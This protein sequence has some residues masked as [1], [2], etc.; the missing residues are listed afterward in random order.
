MQGNGQ[1]LTSMNAP[2]SGPRGGGSACAQPRSSCRAH[3]GTASSTEIL[4]F[5]GMAGPLM[6]ADSDRT[7]GESRR[8]MVTRTPLSVT[9][10]AK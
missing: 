5:C 8:P 6:T 1:P 4:R 7:P 3:Q 2:V 9:I 10:V